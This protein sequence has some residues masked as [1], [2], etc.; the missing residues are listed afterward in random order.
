[1]EE[2]EDKCKPKKVCWQGFKQGRCPMKKLENEK[3]FY[4]TLLVIAIGIILWK[5]Q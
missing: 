2:C 3:L 1:M 5:F 4:A